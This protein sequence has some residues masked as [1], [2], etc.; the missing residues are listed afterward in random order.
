MFLLGI[1]W[2]LK[3]LRTQKYVNM[4]YNAIHCTISL[5]TIKKNSKMTQALVEIT[6]YI[7]HSWL[8]V[9]MCKQ[10]N[11]LILWSSFSHF[12]SLSCCPCSTFSVRLFLC[13]F[14]FCIWL[15]WGFIFTIHCCNAIIEKYIN[16]V[17]DYFG[18]KYILYHFVSV[19]CLTF[20]TF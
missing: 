12:I 15:L 11:N 6:D 2:S 14:W 4:F 5:S 17:Q 9:S 8:V 1:F 20:F 16:E 7:Y 19:L 18:L 3:Y 10:Y 13:L